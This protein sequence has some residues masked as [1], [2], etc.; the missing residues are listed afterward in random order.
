[1]IADYLRLALR[2]EPTVPQTDMFALT[3]DCLSEQLRSLNSWH[4][5]K[6]AISHGPGQ[7]PAI[8]PL[9]PT[10]IAPIT[11]SDALLAATLLN[12]RPRMRFGYDSPRNVFAAM[13]GLSSFVVR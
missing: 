1:V 6:F 2:I 4:F 10:S 7:E 3:G 13:S 9:K 12:R 11:Q 5:C 8:I